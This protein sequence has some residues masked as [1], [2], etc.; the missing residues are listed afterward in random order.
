MKLGIFDK[1]KTTLAQ[2]DHVKKTLSNTKPTAINFEIERQTDV[3]QSVGS[4]GEP[5]RS[6]TGVE[7]L[8]RIFEASGKR[9]FQPVSLCLHCKTEVV[10]SGFA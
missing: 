8:L 10:V 3:C 4:L 7:R 6:L 9:K 2:V 1:Y 5:I